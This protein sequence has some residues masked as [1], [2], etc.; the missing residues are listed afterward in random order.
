MASKIRYTFFIICVFLLFSIKVEAIDL[1]GGYN[2]NAPLG[3]IDFGRNVINIPP[4]EPKPQPKV[5]Q[6]EQVKKVPVVEQK[7][8]KSINSDKMASKPTPKE[9]PVVSVKPKP[10]EKPTAVAKPEPKKTIDKPI[11]EEKP[12]VVAQPKQDQIIVSQPIVAKKK[13][14]KKTEPYTVKNVVHENIHIEPQFVEGGG[15]T[16][17]I[18]SLKD[19]NRVVCP[20]DDIGFVTY[21]KEKHWQ[22]CFC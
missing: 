15:Y 22:K 16:D 12:A 5:E 8:S 2:N 18:I 11:K 9:K 6:V 10:S 14:I 17:V 4:E 20:A 21:S 1:M 13:T 3:G 19:M 7:E